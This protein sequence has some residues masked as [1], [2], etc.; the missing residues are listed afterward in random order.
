MIPIV[1]STDHNFIMPTGVAILSMLECAINTKLDIFILQSDS[2]T[3]NDRETLRSIV[4]PYSSRISFISMGEWFDGAFEIREITIAT[5]YRLLIPWII[6]QYD[7]IIYCDGDVI[8]CDN[9]K[10]LYEL[11][12]GEN[13]VAGVCPSEYDKNAFKDYAWKIGV[14]VNKYLNAGIMLINSKKQREAK[15]DKEY[16]L[17]AKKRYLL[18][19]QDIINIVCD[20]HKA[21]MPMRYNCPPD[22]G[23]LKGMCIIHYFGKKPWK[24]FTHSWIRWW[25]VYRRSPFYDEVF[26]LE[27]ANKILNPIYTQRQLASLFMRKNMPWVMSMRKNILS[28]SYI[29]KYLLGKGE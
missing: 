12:L 6:S 18:Q 20:H 5:Y 15:I 19:D 2:V 9:I 23:H 22:K 3:E 28:N 10:E 8:F 25:E 7:K 4:L 13:Y 17:H 11:P 24:T 1:F 26:E 14:D 21:Y 29:K 16:L 27:V